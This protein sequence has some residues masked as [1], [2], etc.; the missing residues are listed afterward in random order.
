MAWP[1]LQLVA[2]PNPN[3][4]VLYDFNRITTQ[5]TE[6]ASYQLTPAEWRG[7]PGVS[8]GTEDYSQIQLTHLLDSTDVGAAAALQAL[9]R[10]LLK[11]YGWLLI[12][13]RP[14]AAPRWLRVWRTTPGQLS[15]D[16][17]RMR[18]DLGTGQAGKY[19]ISITLKADPYLVGERIPLVSAQQVL[20]DPGVSTAN[21]VP[22]NTSSIETDA[23]GWMATDPVFDDPTIARSTTRAAPG[24]GSASLLVTWP[25]STAGSAA[26]RTASMISGLVVGATYLASAQ[27][28]VPGGAPQV[29]LNVGLLSAGAGS[30]ISSTT[31]GAWNQLT[32]IFTATATS[33]HIYL[34]NHQASTSGQQVWLDDVQVTLVNATSPTQVVLPDVIGDAPAAAV[35]TV[36]PGQRTDGALHLMHTTPVLASGTAAPVTLQVGT[37]DGWTPDG[38]GSAS[39]DPDW[40]GGSYRQTSAATGKLVKTI[41]IQPGK[42]LVLMRAGAPSGATG[43]W[44]FAFRAGPL[45]PR[46]TSDPIAVIAGGADQAHWHRIGVVQVPQNS[47]LPPET[48]A[49]EPTISTEVG[50]LFE[51][52][53][54]SGNVN[55]D[56]LLLLPVSDDSS[57]LLW[58]VAASVADSS[59]TADTVDGEQELL[60]SRDP[61]SGVLKPRPSSAQGGW[62]RLCPG[63]NAL[64]LL[65]GTS[66]GAALGTTLGSEV[67]DR[68]DAITWSQL[69]TVTYRPQYL[70]PAP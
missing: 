40:S 12:Q 48:L 61:S 66:G 53:S 54:G 56:C 25:T 63:P 67:T 55:L 38:V 57:T 60:Y 58:L 16:R 17:V 41:T 22:A 2:S 50:F 70:W 9:G 33:H 10:L 32:F 20:N 35:V 69:V 26:T 68:P 21:L 39:T 18:P 7:E 59:I 6:R 43:V 14:D 13:I 31:T 8:G 62:P 46:A 11:P 28:W 30:V 42:Y 45:A 34:I 24:A 23:S 65:G 64:Y 5:K 37:S 44:R 15:W 19:E 1:R 4:T 51:R 3:A 36:T 29:R 52:V 49:A 27:V 47:T